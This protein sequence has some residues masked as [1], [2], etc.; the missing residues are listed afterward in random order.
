MHSF[1][2][3]VITQQAES[4]KHLLNPESKQWSCTEAFSNEMTQLIQRLTTHYIKRAAL[5]GAHRID[6]EGDKVVKIQEGEKEPKVKKRKKR[7][8]MEIRESDFDY[9]W[10]TIE[11]DAIK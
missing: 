1:I 10:Q 8:K 2:Q 9:A 5:F 7:P 4:L 6:T 3:G 11:Q